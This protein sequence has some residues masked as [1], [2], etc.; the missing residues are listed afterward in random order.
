MNLNVFRHS[1][2]FLRAPGIRLQNTIIQKLIT[3]VN[4]LPEV[5]RYNVLCDSSQLTKI[6]K[7][8]FCKSSIVMANINKETR[9]KEVKKKVGI[10]Q[11]TSISDKDANFQQAKTLIEKAVAL[12]AEVS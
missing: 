2:L 10:V 12:N 11:M 4:S 7:R 3:L 8:H 6:N 9:S 1:S 5:G